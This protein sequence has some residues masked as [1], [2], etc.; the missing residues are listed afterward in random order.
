MGYIVRRNGRWQAAYRGPDRRERTKTFDR[1]VDAERWLATTE[2]DLLRGEWVDPRSGQ[3]LFEECAQRWL[4]SKVDLAP[5]SIDKV[6]RHVRR[7]TSP[8]SDTSRWATSSPPTCEAGWPRCRR[9]GW[10][11]TLS[12]PST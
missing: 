6:E 9:P 5:S 4:A 7:H 10:P 3:V 8:S 12:R 2:A 11:P 1:K